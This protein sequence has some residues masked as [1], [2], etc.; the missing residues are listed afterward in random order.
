MND[1]IWGKRNVWISAYFSLFYT[2]T[3]LAQ[4]ILYNQFSER[5]IQSGVTHVFFVVTTDPIMGPRGRVLS[6]HPASLVLTYAA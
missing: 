2:Q 6:F 4:F 5:Y 3:M 1:V